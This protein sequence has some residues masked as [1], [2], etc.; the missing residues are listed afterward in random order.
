MELC[1]NGE[2]FDLINRQGHLS[3]VTAAKI[4][5]QLYSAICYLHQQKIAHR[6]IKTENILFDGEMNVKL[7]DFGL[8]NRYGED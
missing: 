4:F 1:E 7:I 2:L 5:T 3:E 8:A 6:D